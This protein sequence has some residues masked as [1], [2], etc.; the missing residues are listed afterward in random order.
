MIA[1]QL[2]R[3]PEM[4]NRKTKRVRPTDKSRNRPSSRHAV[5]RGGSLFPAELSGNELKAVQ[6]LLH[7]LINPD[8]QAYKL[9]RE[10]IAR[11]IGTQHS[12]LKRGDAVLFLLSCSLSVR[13]LS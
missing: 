3:S 2:S 12:D 9:A 10:T 4:V 8:D 5:R 6:Q 13:A 11:V 7:G 1:S